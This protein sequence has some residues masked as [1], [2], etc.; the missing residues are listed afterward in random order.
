MEL[1]KRLVSNNGRVRYVPDSTV[2]HYHAE[3]WAQVKRRFERE[4]I[5]LKK[6]MPQVHV[7]R[8]DTI[9]YI[10]SSVINDFRC[11]WRENVLTEKASEI[12]FY[13][14]NQYFGAYT[15]NHEHREL[16]RKEKEK[17]FFPYQ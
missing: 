7:T 3:N 6:I 1:A 15:G 14:W 2:I 13:R 9:R 17:Y 11:A 12:V 8:Q 5:A 16:S 10:I 4:A